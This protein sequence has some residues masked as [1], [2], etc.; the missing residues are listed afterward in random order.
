MS[1][2]KN[3]FLVGY[4]CPGNV[5]PGLTG[6]V[7]FRHGNVVPFL[8][9][10]SL[11]VFDGRVVP[12]RSIPGTP[13][14]GNVEPCALVGMV[15]PNRFG[16]VVCE[17]RSPLRRGKLVSPAE[18]FGRPGRFKSPVSHEFNPPNRSRFKFDSSSLE[19]LEDVAGLSSSWV[20]SCQWAG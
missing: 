14:A 13:R 2:A 10:E 1:F 8:K 17:N 20:S 3:G 7:S 12:K 6:F 15:V 19:P 16:N 18:E 9:M 4:L 5:V 11:A